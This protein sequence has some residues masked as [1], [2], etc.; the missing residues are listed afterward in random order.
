MA[1]YDLGIC[2]QVL[3]CF[4]RNAKS[5]LIILN[6]KSTSGGTLR[7]FSN[8]TNSKR[9]CQN[10]IK[11]HHSVVDR[12]SRKC[13]S[14][15]IVCCNLWQSMHAPHLILE[16]ERDHLL[17]HEHHGTSLWGI[18]WRCSSAHLAYIQKSTW[19]FT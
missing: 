16:T 14:C 15:R 11:V 4:N 18:P 6:N 3:G 7:A 9:I 17:C 5:H 8:Q 12:R 19:I 2:I 13:S 10:R 1:N